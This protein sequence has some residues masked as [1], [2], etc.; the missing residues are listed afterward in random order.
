MSARCRPPARRTSKAA[1]VGLKFPAAVEKV[2]VQKGREPKVT[3]VV[4]FFADPP[5]EPSEITQVASAADV[6]EIALRDILREELG[7]T[8]TVG[9]GFSQ[10]PHQRGGGHIVGQLHGRPREPREDDRS[11]DAGDRSG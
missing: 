6:L 10:E 8:Y 3:T 2:T 4:S 11:R 1:D 9:V 7:E 5:Q